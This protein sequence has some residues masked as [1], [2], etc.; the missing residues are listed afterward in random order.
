[1]QT[2]L[3][4][5]VRFSFA[6]YGHFECYR[7]VTTVAERQA[8]EGRKGI[9]L[10]LTGVPA[11]SKKHFHRAW[12]GRSWTSNTS[13]WVARGASRHLQSL[14]Q[15][16]RVRIQ[17]SFLR[18]SKT[19]GSWRTSTPATRCVSSDPSQRKNCQ[20]HQGG[21]TEILSCKQALLNA[22]K[23]LRISS[24]HSLKSSTTKILTVELSVISRVSLRLGGA[25]VALF[26]P[27]KVLPYSH[28]TSL[29]STILQ[30]TG[31]GEGSSLQDRSKA[32]LGANTI[33]SPCTPPMLNLGKIWDIR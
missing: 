9:R 7:D 21:L 29:S 14:A 5:S 19:E 30:R 27:L 20:T 25:I 24:R 23:I 2:G 16:R 31:D 26:V 13:T 1:M 22:C 10:R 15:L 17:S 32:K 8:R 28:K 3:I 11:K 4:T 33:A 18:R 6:F 12:G